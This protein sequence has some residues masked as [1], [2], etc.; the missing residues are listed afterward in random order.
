MKAEGDDP[1]ASQGTEIFMGTSPAQPDVVSLFIHE[2]FGFRRR[3]GAPFG[4]CPLRRDEISVVRQ[5]VEKLCR[6]RGGE[7]SCVKTEMGVWLAED[8]CL[9]RCGQRRLVR[10]GRVEAVMNQWRRR[11]A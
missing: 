9:E 2:D 1:G 3:N 6:R 8:G 4:A 7:I 5:R 10:A 11:V